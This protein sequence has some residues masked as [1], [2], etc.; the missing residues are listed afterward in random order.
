MAS[1]PVTINSALLDALEPLTKLL[2]TVGQAAL[3]SAAGRPQAVVSSP[4]TGGGSS[5][6]GDIGGALL[7]VFGPGLGLSSGS[8]G[9]GGIGGTL[10]DAFG[11]GLSLGPLISGIA[12]LFGGGDSSAPAP[13]VKFAMP[14][15]LSANAGV[16]E[17]DP[18]GAFGVDQSQGGT[19]RAVATAAPTQITVQVQAMDSQSFLDHSSDI[20][21]A[22]RQAMLQS[23]VLNDVI[24]E[25]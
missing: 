24:R 19:P 25:V 11:S 9:S 6:A 7:D 2:Q 15:S 21:L 18:T 12:S 13:L 10:L 16:N 1:D 4:A 3:E 14:P 8:S 20:A 23:S 22:V 17:S 5:V